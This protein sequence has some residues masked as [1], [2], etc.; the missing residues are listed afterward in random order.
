MD[1]C[2]KVSEF[3]ATAKRILKEG[4]LG[5]TSEVRSSDLGLALG[6]LHRGGLWTL[7]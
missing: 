2:V 6:L 4:M 3:L 7:L 5:D 1:S